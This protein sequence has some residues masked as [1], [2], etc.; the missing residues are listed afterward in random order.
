MHFSTRCLIALGLVVPVAM[1]SSA[2]AQ[3]KSTKS[4]LLSQRIDHHIAAGWKQNGVKPAVPADDAEFLRRVYLDLVG[5]IPSVTEARKFLDDKSAD[6]RRRL[7]DRL[8]D[9]PRHAAHFA[10]LWRVWWLPETTSNPEVQ[11]LG[12]DFETWLSAKL[13]KNTAYDKMV[14]EIFALP[15]NEGTLDYAYYDVNPLMVSPAAFYQAKANKPEEMAAGVGRAF[16]GLKL[17]CAQCHDHPFADWRREEFWGIAAFFAGLPRRPEAQYISGRVA[18]FEENVSVR[19]IAIPDTK[20]MVK[21]AFLDKTEPKFKDKVSPRLT[22]GAWIT[23]KENPYFARA[24]VNRLWAYFLGVGLIEPVDEIAGGQ[25]KAS[26]PELLDEL[27]RQFIDSGYDLKFVTRAIVNSHTY[28]LSSAGTNGAE[29]RLFARMAMRGLSAE[30]LWDSLAQATAFDTVERKRLPQNF[31]RRNEFLARF[32]RGT[33]KPSEQQTS[34]L[35]ALTLMNG[36]IASDATSLEKSET[37]A[38][39]ADA[40]FLDTAAKIETLY[41]AVLS[42]RPTERERER[43]VKYVDERGDRALADVFWALLNG[44]EFVLNH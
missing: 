28:Q 20:R 4:E 8:L 6:K 34:I 12:R 5:R 30:Q 14:Q 41:L 36:K 29:P 39:V 31:K 15:V 32:T 9:S 27:A 18:Q 2:A 19:E 16:L 44:P 10:N 11:Y 1:Q 23:A 38:A 3:E 17:D 42:R 40:P 25:N 7:V 21:A 43:M 33:D 35:Q 13:K 22:L 26:H 37:L 24:A